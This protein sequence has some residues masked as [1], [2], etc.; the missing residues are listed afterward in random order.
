[1]SNQ[2]K[3]QFGEKAGKKRK[4]F[5]NISYQINIIKIILKKFII[6]IK[7]IDILFYVILRLIQ[8]WNPLLIQGNLDFF[9]ILSNK[10]MRDILL[11]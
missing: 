3:N 10:K 11:R 8:S 2:N 9:L 5:P 7:K 4:S 6:N 1:M